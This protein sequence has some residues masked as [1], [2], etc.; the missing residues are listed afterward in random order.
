MTYVLLTTARTE[1]S[2]AS[3]LKVKVSTC[4]KVSRKAILSIP[5]CLAH[6]TYI[7]QKATDINSLH[8]KFLH[9]SISV[10]K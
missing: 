4:C 6:V 2:R 9:Y 7:L 5:L 8:F 1:V 3:V 10:L